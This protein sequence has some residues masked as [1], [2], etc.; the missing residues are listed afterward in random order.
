M[1]V[2][3]VDDRALRLRQQASGRQPRPTPRFVEPT[4]SPVDFLASN[5]L[6]AAPQIAKSAAATNIFNPVPLATE[7]VNEGRLPTGAEA[8]LDAG[9]LAAGFLPVG[10]AASQL[11]AI[12]KRLNKSTDV[13]DF[14]TPETMRNAARP[15]DANEGLFRPG[16]QSFDYKSVPEPASP[17]TF[18][19]VPTEKLA[20]LREFDRA[21]EPVGRKYTGPDNLRKL[22]EHMAEGGKLSDPTGVAY[23]PDQQWG[24]LA[25]GNHRLALAEALGLEQMPTTVWRQQGLPLKLLFARNADGQAVGRRIGPLD[26]NQLRRDPF[27]DFPESVGDFYVPPTMNP[28]LLKYFQQ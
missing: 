13:G 20:P 9:F 27:G 26:T 21:A 11:N 4:P 5:Y 28:Y 23:Y 3:M 7:A 8:G 24:Y 10:K 22:A 18:G 2:G 16:A 25:E 12:V 17:Y 19:L 6:R 1:I 15:N 14:I